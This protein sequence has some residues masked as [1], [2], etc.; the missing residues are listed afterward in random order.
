VQSPPYFRRPAGETKALRRLAQEAPGHV[1]SAHIDPDTLLF[2][3]EFSNRTHVHDLLLQQ[4][5][6][7]REKKK[8]T[9]AP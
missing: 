3:D 1:L 6:P 5:C 2:P 9:A 8:K 4:I 7:Q